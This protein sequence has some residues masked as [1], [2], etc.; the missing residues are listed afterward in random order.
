M[1]LREIE[2]GLIANLFRRLIWWIQ[3]EYLLPAALILGAFLFIL[4]WIMVVVF[5]FEHHPVT[6]IVAFAPG[7]NVL[8]LPTIWHRV[9]GW[10]ITGF[11]GLCIAAAAWGE[12]L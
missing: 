1:L 12:V 9:S 5:G 7:L 8:I 11:V 3:M 4:S 10:V 2:A 6:G